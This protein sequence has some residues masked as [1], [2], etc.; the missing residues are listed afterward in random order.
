MGS[1]WRTIDEIKHID[2]LGVKKNFIPGAP[3][4]PEEIDL[5][6][7]L[8]LLEEYKKS[9]QVRANWGDINP[10]ELAQAVDDRI[11]AVKAAIARRS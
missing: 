2:Q 8:R 9:M 4:K 7:R 3:E 10:T 6:S 1:W 11:A 5:V